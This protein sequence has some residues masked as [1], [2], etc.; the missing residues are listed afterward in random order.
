MEFCQVKVLRVFVSLFSVYHYLCRTLNL[1]HTVYIIVA[2]KTNKPWAL[3]RHFVS[4]VA[5]I[6]SIWWSCE[7]ELLFSLPSPMYTIYS[8]FSSSFLSQFCA[9]FPASSFLLSPSLF[10]HPLFSVVFI[11][12]L[13]AF[14][15]LRPI[16]YGVWRR[17]KTSLMYSNISSHGWCARRH[18]FCEAVVFT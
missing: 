18:P 15:L 16:I 13:S 3:H 14:I 6:G 2:F 5:L 11:C 8:S 1:L 7:T 12:P 10:L 9:S 4:K 17:I